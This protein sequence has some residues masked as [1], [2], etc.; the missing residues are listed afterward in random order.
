MAPD[1]PA[2]IGI[3]EIENREVLED[4]AEVIGSEKDSMV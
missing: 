2:I 1:G 4:L 3:A